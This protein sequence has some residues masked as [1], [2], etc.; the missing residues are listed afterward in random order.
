MLQDRR[1]TFEQLAAEV[2]QHGGEHHRMA[3]RGS[4]ILVID[5]WHSV[6]EFDTF[7]PDKGL[8]KVLDDLGFAEAPEVSYWHP[9]PDP[10]EF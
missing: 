5:E 9:I 4:E 3:V 7:Y 6:E 8:L 2:R 10:G 1:E